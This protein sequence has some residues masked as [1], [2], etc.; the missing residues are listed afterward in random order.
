MKEAKHRREYTIGFHLYKVLI[1]LIYGVRSQHSGYLHREIMI[2]RGH[3]RGLPGIFG[4]ILFLEL[5][6]VLHRYVYFE[7][8]ENWTLKMYALFCIFVIFPLKS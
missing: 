7:N 4:D 6:A 5:D 1:K 2:G 3:K 8:S